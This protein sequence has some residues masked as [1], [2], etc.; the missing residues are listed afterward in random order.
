M[1]GEPHQN[2]NSVVTEINIESFIRLIITIVKTQHNNL[3]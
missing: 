2:Q 1:F 3:Q